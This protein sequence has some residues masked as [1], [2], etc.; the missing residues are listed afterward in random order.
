MAPTVANT[1]TWLR[2]I[3][4]LELLFAAHGPVRE[5]T[6]PLIKL[7]VE[8]T[9]LTMIVASLYNRQPSLMARQEWK[10]A[11][12]DQSIHNSAFSYLLDALAQLPTLYREQDAL[13]HGSQTEST[14]DIDG[15]SHSYLPTGATSLLGRALALLSDIR[16]QR[17]Q[18]IDSHPNTEFHRL[19][20]T[21]VSSVSACPFPVVTHFSSL[22]VANA[23]TLYNCFLILINQFI[24]SVYHLLTKDHDDLTRK[25]ASDQV[26]D[27]A[28]DILKSIDYHLPFTLPTPNPSVH[29]SGPRNF[30]LI[31][32]M[33]VAFQ[34]LSLSEV[35]DSDLHKLW[36]K[37]V[38][39]VIKG[40]AGPW[41]SEHI[42]RLE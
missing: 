41:A 29:G 17:A 30:Y 39:D 27:A 13:V 18:W 32:P 21:P 23:F 40:R 38:F 6:D 35:P 33:R 14:T 28:L 12:A 25:L 4:G 36:L 24:G 19:P 9:R 7:L 34:A 37:D 31:F 3:Q 11:N 16:A 10:A 42:F 15:T 1:H 20:H 2:H 22:H 26:Y 8:S 5:S